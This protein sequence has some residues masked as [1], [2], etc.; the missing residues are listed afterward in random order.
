MFD[1]L[2]LYSRSNHIIAQIGLPWWNVG[3][4]HDL[5]FESPDARYSRETFKRIFGATYDA[6]EHGDA[7]FIMLDNVDYLGPGTGPTMGKGKY[8]GRIGERQLAFVAN[9]LKEIPA[10][11]LI[12]L[13][14]H[15]PLETYVDPKSTS[16]NTADAADLLA[17][18]GERPS[19]SF[20]GHT[21]T[22]EHHYL[23]RPGASADAPAH[24][25]LR[26]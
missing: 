25:H 11:K 1:D 7:L 13:V 10:D 20:A 9:L 21:H 22:T 24:H 26:G 17:L 15:M 4:N 18:L 3:G 14:M 6:L 5:N 23:T 8:I 2:S 12:V 19:V 16:Q